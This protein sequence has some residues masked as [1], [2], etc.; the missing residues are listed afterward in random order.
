MIENES[1][2]TTTTN[3]NNNIK[4]K[5]FTF[6]L[7][8]FDESKPIQ[9]I[10]FEY[11]ITQIGGDLLPLHLKSFL[12]EDVYQI[13][14]TPLKRMSPPPKQY[15][16]QSHQFYDEQLFL[17]ASGVYA[18]HCLN[19][20]TNPKY[21]NIRATSLSM[22]CGLLS[23]RFYGDVF[24]SRLGYF[25]NYHDSNNDIIMMNTSIMLNEI[26]YATYV[27]PDVRRSIVE[28]LLEQRQRKNDN[29]ESNNNNDEEREKV[30]FPDWILEATRS[31]YEDAAALSFLAETMNRQN[32]QNDDESSSINKNNII[33][34]NDDTTVGDDS[35]NQNNLET[36]PIVTTETKSSVKSVVV[37]TS[38]C[39][40]CRR[41]SKYLCPN[42]EGMYFCE[43]P[44]SCQQDG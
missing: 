9:E 23:Q 15:Q 37:Q 19:S 21:A 26:K 22:A 28:T 4:P 24:L 1:N 34:N 10:E 12:D 3:N 14:A 29:N 6:I 35:T 33:D 38:L 7:I 5:S 13:E 27:S 11:P 42:C 36:K 32:H 2:I 8:P 18:Y 25:Q 16:Q 43:S 17:D 30:V 44:R 41:P 31:N 20:D 40:H 39:L